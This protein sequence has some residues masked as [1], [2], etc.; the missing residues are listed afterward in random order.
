MEMRGHGL[1]WR[2][3]GRERIAKKERVEN[4]VSDLGKKR[5]KKEEGTKQSF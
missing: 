3:P 5:K 1:S 4:S 2:H